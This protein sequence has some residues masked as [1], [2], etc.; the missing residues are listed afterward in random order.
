MICF[1]LDLPHNGTMKIEVRFV[2]EMHRI[3][4]MRTEDALFCRN[5]LIMVTLRTQ[6]PLLHHNRERVHA[7]SYNSGS[8]V[9]IWL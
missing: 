1:M 5:G 9:R 7:K 8:L 6:D 4:I 2:L 3:E